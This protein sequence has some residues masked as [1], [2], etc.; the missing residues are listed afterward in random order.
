MRKNHKLFWACLFFAFLFASSNC[1]ADESDLFFGAADPDV[2]MILD[3]SGSMNGL[4]ALPDSDD[5]VYSATGC[6]DPGPFYTSSG[7]GHTVSCKIE[8]VPAPGPFYGLD[9]DTKCLGPYYRT[10]GSGHSKDCARLAIAKRAI[11]GFL[12]AD[13]SK[14][15]DAKDDTTL[16]L[17]LGYMRFY[18]CVY[19]TTPALGG[20][21]GQNY[22]TGCNTVIKTI[23]TTAADVWAKVNAESAGG[24][25]PLAYA[26]NEARA[27]LDYNKSLDPA[28]SCRKKFILLVTDGWDTMSC[29]F[30]GGTDLTPLYKNRKSFVAA[31]KAANDAGYPVYVVG[32]GEDLSQV[33]KNTLN[34]AAYYGGTNNGTLTDDSGNTSAITPSANPCTEPSTN[35]PGSALLSG[36]AFVT[37]GADQLGQALKT[38]FSNIQQAKYSFSLASVASSRTE[39]ENYIYAASFQPVSNDSFWKGYLK[40]YQINTNGSNGN[41]IWEMG[42]V[43]QAK[44][45]TSRNI[46]TLCDDLIGT[47]MIR[48]ETTYV[49]PQYLGL[50]STD[51]ATRD[52]IVGFFRGDTAYNKEGWK[53]GDA[54]HSNPL[55]I[56]T[57]SIYFNDNRDSQNAFD[58][59]RTNHQRTSENGK[60]LVVLGANDG[61]FHAFKTKNLEP[62]E[63][64]SFIP[65]N[66]LPKLKLITHSDHPTTLVHQYY[67]DGPVSGADVWLGTGDGTKKMPND[68]HTMVIVGEGRGPRDDANIPTYLWSSSPYC[69]SDFNK[70]YTSQYPYYC[71]YYAFDFTD[72]TSTQPTLRWAS[73]KVTS[74]EHGKHL[75]EPWSKMAIGRVKINGNEKWVGFIGGGYSLHGKYEDDDDFTAYKRAKGFFV[76]DLSDGSILWAYTTNI[77]NSIPAPP[78]IVDK[79]NDGFVDTAYIA[80]LGG[81]IWKF[82]FCNFET[83]T[84]DPNQWNG[85][86]FFDASGID[87]T[88]PVFTS[89]TAAKDTVGNLWVFFGTG[90]KINPAG[91][92]Y[93]DYFFAVK[94]QNPT[95]AY[96]KDDLEYIG[97]KTAYSDQGSQ[98]H[99]WYIDLPG[100]GEKM[101]ADPTVFGGVVFF[102]TFTP[103]QDTNPCAKS[104]TGTL[105]AMAMEPVVI[106]GKYYQPGK[107]LFSETGQRSMTLGLGIPSAPVLSQKPKS[108]ATDVF[109]TVSGGGGKDAEIRTSSEYQA[110]PLTQLLN[111]NQ[112]SANIVHWRDRRI[113]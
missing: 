70:K 9:T 50:A 103:S 15:I 88:H 109:V 40:K 71:G 67:V 91:I 13:G 53:L 96:T 85:S 27:Y 1:L 2:V 110:S 108:G 66:L 51:T 104:G 32:F 14:T 80:D 3:L 59:F 81:N 30:S 112:P 75:D 106:N 28:K 52:K 79:D 41:M 33:D 35:D 90:N 99:G 37:S 7:T 25:T 22:S 11:F 84:C 113:R 86:L 36:Y 39:D 6:S 21:D 94:D 12:D 54:Y 48:F 89:V 42:S 16:G 102:T 4:L 29:G 69:A 60:R 83:T 87:G 49:K 82:N 76:I 63:V 57:P 24:K 44:T 77:D 72:T 20:E 46:Y 56:G 23:P 68:W 38:A 19:N 18:S 61:Q 45:V 97:S 101:L 95:Y 43:L 31:A 100:T 55:T 5:L 98:N 47:S 62:D 105:Y 73:I 17:R 58:Q 26:I 65:P 93:E 92:D 78:A 34:W 107:G 64:W 10:T 8:K 111:M 74:E